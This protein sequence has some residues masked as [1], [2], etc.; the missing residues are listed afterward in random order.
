MSPVIKNKEQTRQRIVGAVGKVLAEGGFKRLGVN[1]IAREAGVDKVLIYRYFGGLAELVTEYRNSIEYWPR[2]E[3][4][5]PVTNE[6]EPED[7]AEILRIFFR[8]YVHA[9]RKRPMTLEIMAW[10][11]T[12]HDDMAIR[13][14]DIR[15]RT[16]LECF[17]QMELHGAE[18]CDLSTGVLILFSAVNSLL[19]KSRCARTVG[20]LN[21][22]E[23]AAWNRIDTTVNAMIHGLF[24]SHDMNKKA[25]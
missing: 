5:I 23:D 16:A 14:E 1:R 10:E 18:K 20:G 19:V 8:N 4:V 24:S 3:E 17:E 22:R 11:M 6:D 21:L 12:A 9:L 25:L 2:P 13:L 15:V 7:G